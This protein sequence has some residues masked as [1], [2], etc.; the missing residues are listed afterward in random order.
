MQCRR[1]R[2]GVL[3][4]R[5]SNCQE[6]DA[7]QAKNPRPTYPIRD[8][9]GQRIINSSKRGVTNSLFAVQRRLQGVQRREPGEKGSLLRSDSP[10]G[11]VGRTFRG[12]SAPYS[13]SYRAH[14]PQLGALTAPTV[15]PRK[16]TSPAL[17]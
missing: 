12:Q 8:P 11:I 3:D 1:N 13:C 4:D 17:E 9:I 5:S 15:Y 6:A 14:A 2:E 16:H 10:G 7:S